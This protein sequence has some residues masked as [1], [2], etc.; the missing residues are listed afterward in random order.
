MKN[1]DSG[2]YVE[3]SGKLIVVEMANVVA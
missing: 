3:K 1:V 2:Y